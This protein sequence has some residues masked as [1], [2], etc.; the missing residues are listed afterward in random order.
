MIQVSM[1][2]SILTMVHPGSSKGKNHPP[3]SRRSAR[4]G[5]KRARNDMSSPEQSRTKKAPKPAAKV[6][7]VVFEEVETDDDVQISSPEVVESV[8]DNGEPIDVDGDGADRS[9]GEASGGAAT[10][11]SLSEPVISL[12][13]VVTRMMAWAMRTVLAFQFD[14][15]QRRSLRRIL[16]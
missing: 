8:R 16:T 11:V 12:T 9:G 14:N 2:W 1:T 5:E 15:Q 3:A 6:S 13:K 4:I 7:N 10:S